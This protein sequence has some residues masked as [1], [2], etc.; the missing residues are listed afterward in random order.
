MATR[1]RGYQQQVEGKKARTN[2]RDRIA[3]RSTAPRADLMRNKSG[4]DL[5][6]AWFNRPER[7]DARGY[8]HHDAT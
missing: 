1:S 3:T 4:L 2:A 8:R 5:A 7:S 6:S